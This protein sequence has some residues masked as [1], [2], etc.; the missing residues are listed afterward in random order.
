[1][2]LPYAFAIPFDVI[3]DA[4][5]AL[6]T[7]TKDDGAAYWHIHVSEPHPGRFAI[8]LPKKSATLPLDDYRLS[9]DALRAV[10]EPGI[11]IANVRAT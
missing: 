6:N 4:L 5:P 1:M 7:T 8:L 3:S 10:P 11:S 2:D 9:L